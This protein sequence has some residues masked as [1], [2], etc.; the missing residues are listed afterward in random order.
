[1][2]TTALVSRARDLEI[3]HVD[4]RVLPLEVDSAGRRH[5]DF[6]QAF[7][8]HVEIPRSLRD[9][10]PPAAGP[11][12]YLWLLRHMYDSSGS[13]TAFHARWLSEVKL[14]YSASGALEH[15]AWCKF[16]EL[17]CF[18]DGLDGAS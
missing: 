8:C 5:R 14:D 17:L 16:F 9:V 3:L 6:K 7:D 1:M 2:D 10:D 13:P 11:A 15:Q 4:T 18:Y 12:T